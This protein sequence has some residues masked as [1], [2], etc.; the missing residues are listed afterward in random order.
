MP[1]EDTM[2]SRIAGQIAGW[3]A[4]KPKWTPVPANQELGAALHLTASNSTFRNAK[5]LLIDRGVL[6]MHRRAYYVA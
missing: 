6:V 1:R 2:A 3:A 4:G 5:R